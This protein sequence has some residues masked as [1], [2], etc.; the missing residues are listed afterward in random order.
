MANSGRENEVGGDGLKMVWGRGRI[1]AI[2]SESFT[3]T[4]EGFGYTET[5]DRRSSTP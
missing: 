3:L 2:D 1:Q 4:K 5:P